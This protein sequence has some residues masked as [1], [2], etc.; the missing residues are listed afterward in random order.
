MFQA[1]WDAMLEDQTCQTCTGGS[2]DP[3]THYFPPIE[4]PPLGWVRGSNGLYHKH[5]PS[6]T[7]Q[8]ATSESHGTASLSLSQ[9]L[10][11]FHT[12]D[13]S[14]AGQNL[15]VGTPA[16]GL[17][18]SS[19]SPDIRSASSGSPLIP[20]VQQTPPVQPDLASLVSNG[21]ED[22]SRGVFC[23]V[24]DLFEK[25]IEAQLQREAEQAEAARRREIEDLEKQARASQQ[26]AEERRRELEQRKRAEFLAAQQQ[27][28]R[29]HQARVQQLK[30]QAARNQSN[31]FLAPRPPAPTHTSTGGFLPPPSVNPTPP[32]QVDTRTRAASVSDSLAPRLLPPSSAA[33]IDPSQIEALIEQKLKA[34]G[35]QPVGL[36]GPIGHCGSHG[37][38]DQICHGGKSSKTLSHTVTNSYMAAKLGV[39]TKP[40]F[41]IAGDIENAD[42][43]KL[44]KVMHAG[45]DKVGT[46]LVLRQM[47]WPHDLLQNSVEGCLVTEHKD[48]TFHQ[49]VNGFIS[50]CLTEVPLERLDRE[51]ANK[52]MLFQ[53]LVNMSFNYEHK[54]MLDAYKEIHNA[55]QMRELDWTDDWSVFD[56]RLKGI[57]SRHQYLPQK[58]TYL[59]S[60]PFPGH[61]KQPAL[62]YSGDSSSAAQSQGKP[63]VNGVPK[64]YMKSVFICIKFNGK[65]GCTEKQSHKSKDEKATLQHICGGCFK[66]SSTKAS[67][68]AFDCEQGP[69]G[70]LFRGW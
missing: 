4:N 50:K 12:T 8:P 69:F 49:F 19:D 53:F 1:I 51:L 39:F 60:V 3:A 21:A 68:R 13:L 15:R 25:E 64:S 6:N 18:R 27:K 16:G 35:H 30:A 33:G 26:S 20:G 45:H 37:S 57:R 29:D 40:V 66:T 23:E 44:S 24:D 58:H 38:I 55:W 52:L 9:S 34:L 62:G 63:D 56:E 17:L 36:S 67:H 11:N 46:G 65:Y 70:A 41:E 14:R 22:A 61:G 31:Q 54:H 28:D 2:C 59:K 7:Q 47:R 43:A 32:V 10:P 5:K 42:M 48:L